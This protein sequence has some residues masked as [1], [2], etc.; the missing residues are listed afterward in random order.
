MGTL[1]DDGRGMK[2]LGKRPTRDSAR[3]T[4]TVQTTRHEK[5]SQHLPEDQFIS[6]EIT[7]ALKFV[8]TDVGSRVI[9]PRTVFR[10]TKEH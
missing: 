3:S 1:P 10:L 8:K 7:P 6:L 9:W 4:R 2:P 5:P